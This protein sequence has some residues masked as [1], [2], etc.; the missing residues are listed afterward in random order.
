MTTIGGKALSYYALSC[1]QEDLGD[2]VDYRMQ[3]LDLID[4]Y[5]GKK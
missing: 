1:S 3:I 4:E 5:Y 2:L